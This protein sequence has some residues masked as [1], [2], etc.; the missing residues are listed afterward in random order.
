MRIVV[1]YA[2]G[3]SAYC[4][5]IV[6]E[7]FHDVWYSPR[8]L[9]GG[10]AWKEFQLRIAWC[11]GMIFLISQGALETPEFHQSLEIARDYG[12]HI[13]PVLID[14]TVTVPE[15]LRLHP[16]I[17][18]SEG[19]TKDAVRMLLRTIHQREQQD[20]SGAKPTAPARPKPL[21]PAA[22]PAR[23]PNGT[24][25]AKTPS[26]ANS[27]PSSY[28]A[29]AANGVL[30]GSDTNAK[31][32]AAAVRAMEAGEFALAVEVIQALKAR[33]DK[34]GGFIDLDKMLAEARTSLAREESHR[35]M[36]DQYRD[37]F[38]VI[39]S[40][41]TRHFGIEAFKRFQE[42]Y[43]DY[44][45]DHL[46]DLLSE[47]PIVRTASHSQLLKIS[48]R[49]PMLE[50]C[51]IPSGKVRIAADSK[52]ARYVESFLMA[53]YPITN[54][55][56][57]LFLKAESG[58]SKTKWWDFSPEARAWRAS[59]DK[60]HPPKYR[61]ADRP[62]ETVNWYDARAF[63]NWLSWVVK[64]DI[65]LPSL[66]QR[67]RAIM[68]EDSRCFPWGDTFDKNRC[69]TKE[70]AIGMTTP[71]NRYPNG[72]NSFGVYDLAGNVWE[73]LSDTLADTD[74]GAEPGYKVMV[75]GGAFVSPHERTH[76]ATW[77]LVPPQTYGQMIGFR[78]ICVNVDLHK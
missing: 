15:S 74:S 73:W 10:Q 17:D 37:I 75:H 32:M 51:E 69:N 38:H 49:I 42:K 62:R 60:P 3:D 28:P 66:L 6:E 70:S 55:Q 8:P 48:A 65:V 63:C 34:S 18:L 26:A 78:V 2:N 20:W 54:L 50:W 25:A 31:D 61:G 33:S 16:F 56:Y 29:N 64:A 57:D 24:A 27:V 47:K 19:L 1:S 41:K 71:V 58:Y 9:S 4:V 72:G 52:G 21:D 35:Q 14:S 39:H 36:E 46:G 40:P 22:N 11:E 59:N 13:F 30:R 5:Q 67:Q 77:Q 12:K 68:G 44:D 7:L 53:R 45:P 23:P 43:P 76:V